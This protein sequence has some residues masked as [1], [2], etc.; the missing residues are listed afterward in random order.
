MAKALLS[1]TI[2][3]FLDAPTSLTYSRQHLLGNKIDH[4]C[5]NFTFGSMEFYSP[6]YPEKYP[7]SIECVRAIEGGCYYIPVHSN[8]KPIPNR[9]STMSTT[10]SFV[11]ARKLKTLMVG[12]FT[13]LSLLFR[14]LCLK[15]Y[16]YFLH[17]SKLH[18][19]N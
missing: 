4:A 14:S 17:R 19:I 12:F 6:N 5:T 15:L 2:V 13:I 8:Q 9:C 16:S 3:F 10:A 1:V 7:N 11:L 18:P